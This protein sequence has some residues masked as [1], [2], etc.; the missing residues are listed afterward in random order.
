VLTAIE[1][2]T[3]ETITI[4]NRGIIMKCQVCGKDFEQKRSWQKFC[5]PKC[6]A[7]NL[8]QKAYVFWWDKKGK[9]HFKKSED[10]KTWT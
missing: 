9:L 5:S 3:M 2:Y 10:M 7:K 8:K 4:T 1:N 6:Q